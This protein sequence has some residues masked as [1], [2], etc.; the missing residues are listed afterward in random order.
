MQPRPVC[1][2][3]FRFGTDVIQHAV[4]LDNI[5]S[6]R[7]RALEL[8]LAARGAVVSDETVRDCGL[9]FGRMKRLHDAE[10]KM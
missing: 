8:I 3:S 9:R 4:W 2:V 10:Q 5:V 1:I 7:L 6:L